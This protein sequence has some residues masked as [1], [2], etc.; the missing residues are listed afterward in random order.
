MEYVQYDHHG[1]E[2]WV[3]EDLW[4][5][6]REHCLCY[7]CAKFY[8]EDEL[9]NCPRA[10]RLY[11]FCVDNDMT[12]PVWE[13]PEF[14]EAVPGPRLRQDNPNQIIVTVDGGVIQ[15]ISYIPKGV[16]VKVIDYDVEGGDPENFTRI[17]QT[18]DKG[19]ID[20]W[21]DAYV[22]VWGSPEDEDND[23]C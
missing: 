10:N 7:S 11:N 2:V 23:W 12:T 18:D 16:T 21:E 17:P 8:P 9:K 14:T 5:R 19:R 3:R 15:D 6:H 20:G 22:S 1:A 4:G 13:C